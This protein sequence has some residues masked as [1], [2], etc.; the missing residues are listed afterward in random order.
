MDSSS[1]SSLKLWASFLAHEKLTAKRVDVE[2]LLKLAEKLV[3][4]GQTPLYRP[5]PMRIRTREL[6]C[7]VAMDMGLDLPAFKYFGKVAMGRGLLDVWERVY[8]ERFGSSYGTNAWAEL[9]R[10]KVVTKL[11]KESR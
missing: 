10:R 4:T 8:V 6:I 3:E 1:R 5:Y 7:T 11:S 2:S 9:N